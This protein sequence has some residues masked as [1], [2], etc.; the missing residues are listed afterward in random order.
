MS[1]PKNRPSQYRQPSRKGKKAWRKNIDLEDIEKKIELNREKEIT[2]GTDNL[3][4]LPG[5]AL[6]QVD[7]DGDEVLKSKLIKRK[8]IKKNIKSKEILDSIKSNSKVPAVT[9]P[10]AAA[11]EKR[12]KIQG[13]SKH[14][15]SRLMALSGRKLGESKLKA[16]VYKEGLVKAGSTDIWG[17]SDVVRTPSGFEL[18][19]KKKK[20]PNELL[21]KSTTGWSVATIAPD[22]IKRA[23]VKVKEFDETPHAGK[24][25]N[26]DK[27]QWKNLINQEYQDE[28]VKEKRRVQM[29]EYKKKIHHLMETLEDDEEK[30]SEDDGSSISDADEQGEE[31]SDQVR[32][33]VNPP[34]KYKKKTKYQRN[35]KKRHEEKV[36]LQHQLKELKTQ[37]HD[38]EKLEAL[39]ESVA[40]EPKGALDH[41]GKVGKEK[42]NK[43]HKLGTKHSVIDGQLEV[44]FSDELSDSLRKLKPEGN[45]L[46]ENV[47]K[48]QSG[49]KIETRVP[50]MKG[51][52]YKQKIT[53]KWTYKDFK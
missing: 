11:S 41:P 1:T 30:D 7:L 21:K 10:K 35:K 26:P 9:H 29:E 13:V 25:Y 6:F 52:R 34:A 46:Y 44:K 12:S 18:N 2:H 19:I 24:S 16:Q 42:K 45:L 3:A 49:G 5:D 36:K 40:S 37:L 4:S 48:L 53:E 32:L 15:L 23:P 33:S 14:E 20:V 22:T 43:K 27:E 28:H 38:L 8:Q 17:E 31:E 47:K 50:I 39:Q 51:R